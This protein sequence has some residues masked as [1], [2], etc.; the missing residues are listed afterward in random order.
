MFAESSL[1][2]IVQPAQGIESKHR[3][4]AAE[5]GGKHAWLGCPPPVKA[6]DHWNEERT[7]LAGAAEDNDVLEKI[8]RIERAHDDHGADQCRDQ[9][10]GSPHALSGDSRIDG[11]LINVAHQ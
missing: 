7:A 8:G 9:V 1:A 5:H 6:Q 11:P 2:K 4:K 3:G 10:T